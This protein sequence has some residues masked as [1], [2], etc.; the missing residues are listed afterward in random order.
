M[1]YGHIFKSSDKRYVWYRYFFKFNS[2]KE[3]AFIAE[4]IEATL[5]EESGDLALLDQQIADWMAAN[6]VENILGFS[7]MNNPALMPD[8]EEYIRML[9][10]EMHRM[11][12]FL[13]SERQEGRA[14]E[15]RFLKLV[16]NS[17]ESY[18]EE[19]YGLADLIKMQDTIMKDAETRACDCIEKAREKFRDSV[20]W[21]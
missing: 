16:E 17:A 21:H 10:R 14:N 7:G 12:S 20:V 19:I 2:E 8:N 18:K 15:K 3:E 1:I 13:E 4:K 11:S 6:G 5:F 9:R